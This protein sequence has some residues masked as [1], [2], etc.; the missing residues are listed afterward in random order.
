ML[1]RQKLAHPLE[2]HQF[3]QKL[4]RHIGFKQPVAIVGENRRMPRRR[5][6]RQANEPAE[7]QIVINLLHQLP[8]R[9]NREERLQ[10]CRPQQHLRWDRRP[11]HARIERLEATIQTTKHF[12]AQLPDRPQRMIQRDALL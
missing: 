12:I 10:Q 4:S 9:T 5:V 2:A 7:Q 11:A 1:A 6:K 8:F 3:T